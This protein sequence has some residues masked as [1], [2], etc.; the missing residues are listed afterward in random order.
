MWSLTCAVPSAMGKPVLPSQWALAHHAEQTGTKNLG[1]N[2][3]W[4]GGEDV[5]RVM[6][7]WA[8][9]GRPL[10]D[11]ECTSGPCDRNR[12][13]KEVV[14]EEDKRRVGKLNGMLGVW[15]APSHHYRDVRG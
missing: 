11:T 4:D 8:H 9:D 6:R 15:P 5:D 12:F 14:R 3:A 13:S 2:T 10:A 7:V 1:V